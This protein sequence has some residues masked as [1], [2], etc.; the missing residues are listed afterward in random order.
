M[1]A[2]L[3][4]LGVVLLALGLA[5]FI[6]LSL[7]HS[8]KYAHYFFGHWFD[9]LWQ[10]QVPLVVTGTGAIILGIIEWRRNKKP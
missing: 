8:E 4:V 7:A 10:V 3:I 5:D 9:A 2:A 6:R 1:K